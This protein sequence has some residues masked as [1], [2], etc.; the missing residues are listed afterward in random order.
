MALMLFFMV[1]GSLIMT[2]FALPLGCFID[3]IPKP[4]LSPREC[5]KALNGKMSVQTIYTPAV[6]RPIIVFQIKYYPF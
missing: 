3:Q 2:I 5:L 1:S 4:N 6:P